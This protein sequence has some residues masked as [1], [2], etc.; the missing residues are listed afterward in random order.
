MGPLVRES[1][2]EEHD[3]KDITTTHKGGAKELGT[4]DCA[5]PG[6][7]EEANTWL[8][9]WLCWVGQLTCTTTHKGGAKEMGTG[10]C[11]KPGPGE[12]ANTWLSGWLCWVGQSTWLMF[13][14]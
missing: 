11:D 12:E 9:G 3:I 2:G 13:A 5:K 8:S 14:S 1:T 4:G 6:P 7:G 10:N